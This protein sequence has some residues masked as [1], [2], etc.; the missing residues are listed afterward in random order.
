MG[1]VVDPR[2]TMLRF[3]C[4]AHAVHGLRKGQRKRVLKVL[5]I[6]VTAK[7]R[8]RSLRTDD[9][10]PGF[11]SAPSPSA[12]GAP[13]ASTDS[14]AAGAGAGAGALAEGAGGSSFL[15]REP[16]PGGGPLVGL[17]LSAG[18]W[19]TWARGR[20]HSL[21]SGLDNPGFTA[22]N[23]QRASSRPQQGRACYCAKSRRQG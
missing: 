12:A 2:E 23:P 4:T 15:L 20:V 21:R 19:R 13:D 5:T 11:P 8:P 3:P 9:F 1:T 17:L 14:S 7:G 22:S 16:V 18:A 6:R 10:L